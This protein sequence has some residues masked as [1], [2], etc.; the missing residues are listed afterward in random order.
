[1]NQS[2][3][4][5][6]TLKGKAQKKSLPTTREQ[7]TLTRIASV[8]IIPDSSIGKQTTLKPAI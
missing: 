5:T 7:C 3:P 4:I 1:M 8:L 2:I 6:K